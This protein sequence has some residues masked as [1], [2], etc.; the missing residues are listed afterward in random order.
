MHK[1]DEDHE[2]LTIA[3]MEKREDMWRS[4]LQEQ[5]EHYEAD[6]EKDL[7]PAIE[8][9]IDVKRVPFYLWRSTW[10]VAASVAVLMGL[11]WMLGQPNNPAGQSPMAVG[12]QEQ[13]NPE[14]VSPE[15][16]APQSPA[17]QLAGV[18][19]MPAAPSPEVLE[20]LQQQRNNDISSAEP[21]DRNDQLT[22][23][24]LPPSRVIPQVGPMQSMMPERLQD[25]D[26]AR[27]SGNQNL[28]VARPRIN[29]PRPAAQ[30]P[31]QQTARGERQSLDLNNLTL[32]DAVSFASN[33]LG[34]LV[35]T[36]L[37]VY[38]EEVDGQEVRTYQLDLFN[39][40]ITRK[41]HKK[42]KS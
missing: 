21:D 37:E 9:K 3:V 19:M 24:P 7:W 26:A 23:S 29:R 35:E 17:V 5:F 28:A 38:T 22:P 33:E 16:V 31:A 14:E 8:E 1:P 34:K 25:L 27:P 39:L 42:S 41:T 30:A 36:P 11:M 18:D 10:L 20:R 4:V 15:V 40:R 2:C 12:P 6:T 32:G 13:T